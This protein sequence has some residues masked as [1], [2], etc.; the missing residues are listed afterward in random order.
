MYIV[1]MQF[2]PK[3]GLNNQQQMANLLINTFYL[4]S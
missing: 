3:G 1:L 2:F 4:S